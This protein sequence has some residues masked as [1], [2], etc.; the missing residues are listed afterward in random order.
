[1]VLAYCYGYKYLNSSTITYSVILLPLPLSCSFRARKQFPEGIVLIHPT[2]G[3]TQPG[4]VDGATR[5]QTYYALQ[6]EVTDPNSE[7]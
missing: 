4:D 1:M 7:L 2:V 5:V 3:P 6:K